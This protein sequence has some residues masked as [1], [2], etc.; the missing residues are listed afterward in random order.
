MQRTLSKLENRMIDDDAGTALMEQIGSA[1]LEDNPKGILE[2]HVNALPDEEKEFLAS[3]MTPEFARAVGVLTGSEDIYNF[4]N[5]R[6]DRSIALVPVP[7]EMAREL[8]KQAQAES[9]ATAAPPAEEMAPGA[10]QA[11]FMSV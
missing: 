3:H 10:S 8:M 7:R 4:L 6:A 1:N 5:E 9:G 2:E 11:P